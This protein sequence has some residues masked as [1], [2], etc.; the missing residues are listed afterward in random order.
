MYKPITVS[1]EINI[2][3]LGKIKHFLL[4]SANCFKI[5]TKIIDNYVNLICEFFW[6][7]DMKV[8]NSHKILI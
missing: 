7:H 1:V 3:K 5:R 6:I 8:V 4:I 2:L